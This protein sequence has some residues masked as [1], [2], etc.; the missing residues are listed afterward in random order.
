MGAPAKDIRGRLVSEAK[1]A[2]ATRAGQRWVGLDIGARSLKLAELERTPAGVRLVKS[3]VQEL[4]APP[5]GGTVDVA[6]WLA[7]ALKE[8]DTAEAH[9]SI[10]GQRAAIRRVIIPMMSKQEL[11]EAVKWQAREQLPFPVEDIVLDFRVTGEVWDKDIKKQDVL[12]AAAP[13]S[14]VRALIESVEQ[15]GVRVASVTPTHAALW[16]AVSLLVPDVTKGSVAVIEIGAHDSDIALVKD[17][18][19]RLTRE[20]AVGSETLTEALVGVVMSEH[21]QITIDR[22]RADALKRRYGVL[23]DAV[24]GNTD[25]GVPLF[26]LSS[27]MRPVLEHLLTELSRALSF[28]KVQVDEAGV[29]R[30]LLCGGGAELKQLQDYLADGL[31]LTVELFNPL[32]RISE[33]AQPLEPEQV[34]EQGPRLGVAIGLALAHGQGLNL[35]PTELQRT[36]AATVTRGKWTRVAQAA[37]AVVFG[38]CAVLWAISAGL[39]GQI[40]HQRGAWAKLAPAYEQSMRISTTSRDFDQTVGQVQRLVDR[41]PIWDGALKELGAL[42]PVTMELSELAITSEGG[43]GAEQVRFRIKG[44][45]SAAAVTGEGSAGQFLETLE[46]SPFFDDVQLVSSQVDAGDPSRVMVEMQG[47]LE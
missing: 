11:A 42:L 24:D 31:G 6:G 20:L 18:Q 35:V 26:H 4:P 9:L 12:V 28:Y 8:F 33:R 27:L 23:P 37:G 47:R 38:V 43:P 34:A 13:R 36:R 2:R 46:A 3:L 7:T 29:S 44:T 39:H 10:G 21:G 17:G 19:I 5:Q 25:D 41:Q 1:R 30:I 45:G 40:V 14:A 32:V 16:Q 15:C 22:S